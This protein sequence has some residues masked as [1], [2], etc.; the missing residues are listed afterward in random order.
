MATV[1]LTA[2]TSSTTQ[3][4]PTATNDASTLTWKKCHGKFQCATLKVPIDYTDN[5]LGTFDIAVIRYR[6]ANQRNRIGS[7]VLNPGGPGASGIEY[8]RNAE[9]IINPDVLERY[10]IVGFDPRGV[11]KSSPIHCLN[12]SEQDASFAGDPKP[13]N[14]AEYK[15]GLRESQEFIEKC[16]ARTPFLENYTT[17]NTARDMELLRKALGDEKLNYMGFSYGTY[18]GTL[19]A[20][21]FPDNVGRFVLDGAVDATIPIEQQTV[22]QAQAFDQALA[23]FI[24]D[25]SRQK[26]CPLPSDATPQF[27]TDLFKKVSM[28]PLTMNSGKS[29]RSITEGLVVIGVISALY[30]D[31]SGW[32]LLRIAIAMAQQG[33]GSAFANLADAYHGR[34]SDGTYIDNQNDANAI[35][36]C[37]DWPHKKSNSQIRSS[38]HRYT[39]AAPVLWPL[40][41]L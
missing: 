20:Q 27:F 35:I 1:L 11:N 41:C 34:K 18:L 13:D 16:L 6:D 38:V 40:R 24:A 7:L 28:Q 19:Y 33:D 17:A 3:P 37:L 29:K 22:A 23:E 39:T 26:D 21:Q 15:Q 30:D 32:P 12:G 4:F 5:S 2:C 25:C 14:D 31:V 10:D 8:A 9:F 36:E